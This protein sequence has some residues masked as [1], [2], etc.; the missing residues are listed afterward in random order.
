MRTRSTRG[1]ARR[2]RTARRTAGRSS[3]SAPGRWGSP[4]RSISRSGAFR[5]SCSTR[6]TPSAWGR[7]RSATRSARSRSSIV[8]AAASGSCRRASSGRSARSSSGDELVYAFDLLPGAGHRRPAFVNLQQYHLEECLVDRLAELPAAEVRWR[9]KVVGVMP[10]DGHVLLARRDA[11]RRLRALVRMADRVRR[12]AQPGAQDAGPR[13]RG[14]DV[15]RSVPDRRHSHEVGLSGRALVLVRSAVSSRAIGAAAPPGG[16]CVAHRFPARLGRRPRSERAARADPAAA[17]CDAGRRRRVRHRVGERLHVPVPADA[18]AS[19]TAACSSP[20]TRR[21]WCRRSARAART[22]ASRMPTISSGSSSSCSPGAP[23]SDCSTPTT[24]S[25]SRPPT[26]TSSTR[27]APPISSRPRARCRGRFAMR[28]LALAKHHAFAREPRQ[29]RPPVAAA[30][31]IGYR[32]STRRTGE[33]ETFAGTMVPG[34]PAADAPVEGAGATVA[35]RSSARRLH[36]ARVRRRRRR[37]GRAA[38]ARRSD[39]LP[40]RAGRRRCRRRPSTLLRDREGL[41]A[42]TLRR[43]GPGRAIF[44]GPTSTSARAG[45]PSMPAE[46]RAAIR[47]A[48]CND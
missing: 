11:G 46:V 40:G 28:C 26:R 17:S 43:R 18:A 3:W 44:C 47:R 25:A 8:W 6:T 35:A 4:R 34:A 41:I 20:A 27:P 45:V 16:R 23:R 1:S 31:A 10:R 7:G 15:P 42:R 5:W 32:R 36:A 22:A 13:G 38:L 37:S 14:T 29:Q 9:H 12:R 21:T 30:R 24:P 39:S 33:G 48:T 19:A 2:S